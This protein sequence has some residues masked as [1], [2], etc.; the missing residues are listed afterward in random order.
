MIKNIIFLLTLNQLFIYASQV[1][2]LI[3]QSE[4]MNK[5]ISN[6]V[7][8]PD[9][10]SEENQLPVIYLLHGYSDNHET[11]MNNAPKIK[12]Y[13]DKYNVII[14]CP[15]ANYSSWYFDSPIDDSIKYETYISSEL[16]KS[17]DRNYNTI[18]NRN[19]RAITGLSMG[20]HGAFYLSFKHQDVWG[21]AGSISG[22]VDIVP[23]PS[24]WDISKQ[25][26]KYSDFPENW[27]NNSVINMVDLLQRDSLKLIFD[28]GIDDFFYDANFRLHNTLK[29]KNIPHDYTERPGMHNWD[30]FSNSVEYHILFFKRYFNKLSLIKNKI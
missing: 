20:G 16:V 13:A 11:W 6:I 22:G 28:C 14:V 25:L 4:S 5:S 12:E 27:K 8:L 30:Y 1:D 21:A 18:D 15:D 29:E 19:G 26:G 9:N 7:I 10:Y 2:T 3:V 23:F 17:V 24:S